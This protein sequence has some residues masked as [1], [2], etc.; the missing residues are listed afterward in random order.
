[1]K[2][3][4]LTPSNDQ[5]LSAEKSLAERPRFSIRFRIIIAFILAFLFSFG[6]ATTSMIF[7]LRLDAR[8][9][10]L[11]QARNFSN[12]IQEARRYEKNFFLYGSRSDLYEA[13]NNA[14][15]AGNV[16]QS[17][18][19]EMGSVL[20]RRD[21]EALTENLNEYKQLLNSLLSQKPGPGGAETAARDPE[22]EENLRASGH[23][24]LLL[25]SD[26]EKKE[27]EKARATAHTFT[28]VALFSLAI[29]LIVMVWL[30]TELTRQILQP[31]GRAVGYTQRIAEGDFTLITP[32][33][34]YRDEFSNLAIAI[35]RMI[36]E[37]HDK[38]EQ[39]VQSRKMAAIG[40]LTSGIAHELNNPL[41]NISL[42]TEA[43]LDGLENYSDDQKK[44]MLQDIFIEVERASG[45]VRNLLDFT[46][47]EKSKFEPIG[48]PELIRTSLAL[49]KNEMN[50]GH[51]EAEASFADPLPRVRGNFRNLEQVFLNLFLNSIQ[52]MPDGG[53]LKVEARRE[54]EKFVRIDVTDTGCGIPQE[55]RT[56]IF[57]PFFTTKEE[58]IGTGLGLSVS[59]GI[60]QK[61][62]GGITV[63]SEVGKG[64]TFHLDLPVFKEN[65]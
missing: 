15:A 48:V 20:R 62:D 57:D 7:I 49:V 64:T 26:L 38:Q 31:L 23:Q 46:R 52:A 12:E 19:S 13:L 50:L 6:I 59:Y 41:N 30:A 53:R 55:N 63:E 42:T 3:D 60:I 9:E 37:L 47:L 18:A 14:N 4:P 22:L 25:A 43:M 40:T 61:M 29:N 28:L 8:Q 51:V 58:G 32:R 45:T 44:K 39:L 24:L 16:L 65:E 11:E 35:N 34:K 33:R 27:R 54:S 5:A 17:A 56:K 1:M 2:S 36:S 10:F 21:F